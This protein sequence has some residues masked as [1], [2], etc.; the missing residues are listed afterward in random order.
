MRRRRSTRSGPDGSPAHSEIFGCFSFFPS[1]NLG[2]FGDGGMVLARD[3]DGAARVRKLRA[4]GSVR[5][6]DHEEIG[7]NSRLDALQAAVLGAKLPHLASWREARRARAGRYRRL[8]AESVPSDA[9]TAPLDAPDGGHVYHQFTIRCAR[10]D[11]LQAHLTAAGIGSAVYYRV[12]LHLQ[13]CFA[14]LGYRAGAFPE[15]ERAA[16]EVL[17]L[18]ISPELTEDDQAYVVAEIAAFYRG[19]GA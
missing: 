3:T 10:R 17:S 11:E 16:S 1:K 9:V 13:P 5:A 19:D 8:F 4:H 6:Y 7:M 12:P 2:G 18:P 14:E 15:A